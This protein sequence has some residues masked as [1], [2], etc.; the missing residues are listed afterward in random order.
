M[1]RQ[2]A[3]RKD[4]TLAKL[5]TARYISSADAR[6][7]REERWDDARKRFD[8]QWVDKTKVKR[9]PYVKGGLV[10][11]NVRTKV[12]HLLTAAEAN[13]R[14]VTVRGSTPENGSV[15]DVAT[16]LVESQFRRSSSDISNN[17]EDALT[18][19]PGVRTQRPERRDHW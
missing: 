6:T 3:K 4:E 14:Y 9:K 10:Y 18:L 16:M 17:N 1:A 2:S 11:R 12:S 8:P 5:I 7:S 13:G 15:G 19:R